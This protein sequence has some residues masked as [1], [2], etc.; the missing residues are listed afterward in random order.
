MNSAARRYVLLTLGI[1][2]AL[3]LGVGTLN[4]LV[5][6]YN[7]FGYNRLGVYISAERESKA[8]EVRRHAHDALL[9]G[10]SRI[11]MIPADQ[12]EGFNFFNAA[13]GGGTS[14]EAYYFL[15]HFA[16]K[17]RLV[18]LGVDL[19]QCDPAALRGDI[20][21]PMGLRTAID[22]VLSLRTAEYSLRT[23]SDHSAGKP[24]AMRADGSFDAREWFRLYD[25]E[26]PAYAHWQLEGL[27]RTC[28]SYTAPPEDRMTYYRRIAE[29]LQGRGIP[30]VV[31]VPPYHEA[32]AKQIQ[33]GPA[34]A[35]Y[36]EWRR[37]LDAIFPLVV[38]LSLG[39]DC[40]AENFFKSD[41]VH[42]KPEV[43]V[44]ML[45]TRVIPVAL[46]AARSAAR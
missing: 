29:L 3:V 23:I 38:D 16:R 9:L 8:T 36:Q 27:K 46:A 5:D 37:K 20:F 35:A 41:A 39:P 21:A 32:L 10:N 24:A 34:L 43:G 25:R 40:A 2:A 18:V 14:E 17:E 30:C 26:N 4:L 15:E 31:F 42:F 44:R 22:D 12:L 6:P 11:A 28:G 19:G 7:R 13:F 1:A 33:S 45:N